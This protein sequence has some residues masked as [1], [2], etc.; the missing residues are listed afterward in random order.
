MQPAKQKVTENMQ[1]TKSTIR[2]TVLATALVLCLAAPLGAAEM[3]ETT[4]TAQRGSLSEQ[5]Y[6]FL[7]KAAKANQ[8][9]VKMGELAQQKG[10]SPSVRDFGQRMINDH[11]QANTE[12]K[13]VA[14][15]L[16]AAVPTQLSEHEQSSYQ[17]LQKLS[18]VDFDKEYAKMMVKDHHK[19]I[20]T[21]EKATKDLQNPELKA[22]A[23]KTL[24][25]L[26]E[27]LRLAEQMQAAVKNE[28]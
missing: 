26:K 10:V 1:Q 9:E 11:G 19:D 28:K 15:Q 13:Q 8:E 27:H 4:T 23:Q 24:G 18:G 17:D 14:S 22:W 21:F 7:Q 20:K 5:D 3:N 25:T 12:L 2:A 16:N 6:H